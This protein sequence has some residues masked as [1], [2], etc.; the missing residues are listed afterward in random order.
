MADLRHIS[1][2]DEDELTELVMRKIRERS[3]APVEPPVVVEPVTLRHEKAPISQAK[4]DQ[5]A[6][7]REKSKVS[8]QRKAAEKTEIAA[9][10]AVETV[11]ARADPPP[12]K[13]GRKARV[14]ESSSEDDEPPVARRSG[15]GPAF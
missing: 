5:L 8:R 9:R 14:V 6:V 2:M 7:A 4:R 15:L 1:E 3:L 13:K 12:R 11:M 10:V